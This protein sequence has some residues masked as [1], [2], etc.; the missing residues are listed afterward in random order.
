M[1]KSDR[2]ILKK[3]AERY[4]KAALD[5]VNS[6]RTALWKALNRCEMERPMVSADQL[7]WHELNP[8][9]ELDCSVE[10]PFWRD[11]ELNLRRELYKWEHFPLDM[12]LNP[13]IRIP[14]AV[15]GNDYGMRI[16][17]ERLA[18]DAENEI[19]SH[20]YENQLKN[21][22]DISKI[23]DMRITHDEH[24]SRQR[25]AEGEELFGSIAPVKSV[26][27]Q[28]HLGMW[29]FLSQWMGVENIYLDIYDRPDFLHAAMERLTAA[30]EAGVR[31]A[32]DL[33]VHDDNALTCHCA[34]VFTDEFFPAAGEGKGPVSGNSWAF[35]MAQLFSGV[36]PEVTKEFEIPYISRLSEYFG[37]FYYGCCDKLDD[38]LELV[39]SIPNLKKISC[40]PWSHRE[41]FAEKIG[42]NYVMSYK[43]NP[44][45]VASADFEAVEK[46]LRQT[47]SCAR[48]FGANL[49]LVLKDVSTVAYRPESLSRW[50]EI[51]M[52]VVRE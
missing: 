33:G 23:K 29:D 24:L 20:R 28:F 8:D 19:V 35:G 22:E 7:P 39:K 17:E 9:G 49:E 1:N 11:I 31:Q 15:S 18:V 16:V 38:R 4:M 37:G 41:S 12:V 51:A 48:D 36:S 44:A 50:A 43:P 26:G 52:K 45:Y 5:P 25:L 10:D 47:V 40:S 30:S 21:P 2:E 42:G 13:F 14:L 34:H 46:D 6:E 32:N 27:I 3:L